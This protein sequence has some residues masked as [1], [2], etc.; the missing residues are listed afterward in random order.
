MTQS[1]D[2]PAEDVLRGYIASTPVFRYRSRTL[3]TMTQTNSVLS[4]GQ[5]APAFTAPDDRGRQVS[6]SDF[7]GKFV[8]LFFYPKD[9][10]PG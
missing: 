3:T 8:V 7:R 4:V 6:L 9:D 10:T 5:K 2:R 1:E